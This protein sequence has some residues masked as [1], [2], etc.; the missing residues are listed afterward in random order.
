MAK[1]QFSAV[2]VELLDERLAGLDPAI[3]LASD[4]LLGDLK[5]ALAERMLEPGDGIPSRR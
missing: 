5:R 2:R 3:I 4:G 1:R